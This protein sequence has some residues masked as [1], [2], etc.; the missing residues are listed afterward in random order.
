MPTVE[1]IG[2]G[3][4]GETGDTEETGETEETGATEEPPTEESSGTAITPVSIVTPGIT[5]S[6]E[7]TSGGDVHTNVF[8]GIE[9]TNRTDDETGRT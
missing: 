9:Q 7:E 2:T 5:M 6:T 3:E 8:S 4:T 1:T